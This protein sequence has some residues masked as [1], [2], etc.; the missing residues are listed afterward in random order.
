MGD[1]YTPGLTVT[2]HAVVR[3]SRRLPLLGDVVV[4]VGDLVK[5]ADVVARTQLP[6]KV[7]LHN[8]ANAIGAMPDELAGKLVVTVGAAVSHKQV[9]AKSVSF[10]GLFKSAYLSPIDG[11]VESASAITGMVV[12]REPP[13]P[14]AVTAYVDGTVVELIDREGAVIETK[15]ALIQGIFGLAGERQ[16][17]LVVLA[18]HPKQTL[19]AADFAAA[20]AGKVVIGGGRLTLEGFRSAMALGVTAV[21][22]GGFAYQDV[23]ELL[24][25]DVGVA[26]TGS[27]QLATT[28]VVT[29]GFGDIAM[30]KATY[31]LLASL[32]GNI[33]S[34]N[35]ATQIRAGVIRP[36]VLVPRRATDAV[37][38]EDV[39]VLGLAVGAPV[40]GIRAPYF[41]RIG[42]ISAL[43][44]Q[45]AMMAS[46]TKVRVVE[47]DF[48][49]DKV[50]VP[51]ANVEVIE[52]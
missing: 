22:C 51:R 9:I 17:E 23:K 38:P 26:V 13:V 11:T 7:H 42:T 20:H 41:G 39:G 43:P 14:V 48:S 15:G 33:A 3:K 29:E 32:A 47:V 52:R 44:A 6:G 30:A 24:G 12:F 19:D 8:V 16:G 5:A 40:R 37:A 4:N 49:G 36:E 2:R 46:E 21:V 50:I 34:V 45:L 25:Y 1:A 28:L 18:T 27:E 10:F 35:G 31:E